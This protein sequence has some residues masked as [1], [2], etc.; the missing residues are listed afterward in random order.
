MFKEHILFCLTKQINQGVGLNATSYKKPSLTTLPLFV[1]FTPELF[2]S[3]YQLFKTE[4]CCF[5]YCYF[6][7]PVLE[8]VTF[9]C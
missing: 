1:T 8:T 4:T 3:S 9:V 7:A 2:V 5:V 6:L